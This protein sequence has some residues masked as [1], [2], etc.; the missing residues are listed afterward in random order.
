MGKM[1]EQPTRHWLERLPIAVDRPLIQVGGMLALVLV[2]LVLRLVVDP[3]LPAGFPFLTFFPAVIICAFLFGARLAVVAGLLCG[4]IAWYCFIDLRGSFRLIPGAPMALVLY[5]VVTGTEI[6]L[7][8]LLQRS[9]ARLAREREVSRVLAETRELLFR[10]LQ[11]R[12][13]NNLQVAAGLLALY[14]GRV[15]D[16]QARGA[17]DEASRRLALIGRISRRLYDATG[18]MR[19]MRGFL[20]PLCADV[21]EAGGREGVRC[22]VHV[23]AGLMLAPDAAVPI[24]LIVA[25]AVANAIEHGFAGRGH[26]LIEVDL[27]RVGASKLRLEVRDDGRGPPDGFDAGET[28]SLGLHIARM[29]AAKLGGTFTLRREAEKTVVA[30]EFLA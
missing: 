3:F 30:L 14:R 20:E 7:V 26:G 13:S 2:G 23:P 19:D 1:E 17:L 10:E 8:Y 9:N 4:L 24:A 15:A 18:A 5:A 6:G 28:H 11:H 25:E 22:V 16:E 27:A 21:V 12:V 29:L